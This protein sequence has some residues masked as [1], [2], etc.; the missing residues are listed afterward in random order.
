MDNCSKMQFAVLDK[1]V[2]FTKSLIFMKERD[3]VELLMQEIKEDISY[4]L[5]YKLD[6]NRLLSLHLEKIEGKVK[7]MSGSPEEVIIKVA[8]DEHASLVVIGKRNTSMIRRAFLETLVPMQELIVSLD[9][10]LY[11]I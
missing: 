3:R 11:L 5:F 6:K 4:K 1:N 9:V 7:S 10:S 8:K 2:L